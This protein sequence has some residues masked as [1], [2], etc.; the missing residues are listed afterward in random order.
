MSRVLL[1]SML[2]GITMCAQIRQA[3]ACGCLHPPEVPSGDFAVNQ[4]AE[5]IIFETEPGFVTAHILINYSGAPSSF[6]WIVPVPEAPEIG[7]SPVSAFAMIDQGTAPR[8]NVQTINECPQS[9]WSCRY[10]DQP[11]CGGFFGGGYDDGASPGGFADA[12]ASGDA[13]GNGGNPPVTVISTQRVGDY[14]TVTFRSDEAGAATQW[15][16]DNGFIVNSTMS[17][18]MEPYINAGMVFVAAKLA[19]GAGIDAIRPIKLRYHAT[20]PMVPLVLTAIATEP[21]LTVTSYIFSDNPYRPQGHPVATIDQT[22]I[23]QDA[24]G[25]TNYPMVVARSI[26]EAGGDAFVR[27][28][29]GTSFIPN[30]FQSG[31]CSSDYDVCSIGN[32]SKCQC[33]LSAF[34]MNDCVGLDDARDGVDFLN[35]M[36]QRHNWL[37]RL[38][39]RISAEE[40]TFD[41]QF[42]PDFTGTAINGQQTLNGQVHSLA[43]CTGDLVEL[44]KYNAIMAQQECASVYCGPG[45]R[46]VGTDQGPACACDG[47]HVAQQYTDLDNKP[48]IACVPTTPPVDLRAGGAQLP[49]ACAGVSC[50][51]GT[52]IDRNGVPVCEC[53]AGTAAAAGTGASPTC[54]NVTRGGTTPGAQDYS[55]GLH[56]VEVCAPAYPQCGDG[57]WL[58]KH[59][60]AKK[61]VACVNVNSE[62]PTALT[63]PGPAPTCDDGFLGCGGCSSNGNPV[64]ACGGAWLVGLLLL[65]RRRG[66][67]R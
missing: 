22:R 59:E 64:A 12:G 13:G 47:E 1:A 62:P 35:T 4:R 30:S 6:A 46:C 9:E 21:N 44:D 5:Q 45:G 2:A 60:V 31:C 18:Y 66:A 41:P 29:S 63:V 24:E 33:P 7:I 67:R 43:G 56:D 34:D 40:M 48:S 14:E 11:S 17:I 8:I 25:R 19:P 51:E 10:H 16:R 39:T 52:C 15:L 58:E 49:D 32:D 54:A 42:E 53:E 23:S 57:G 61:G 27:E 26:D 20:Y 38:T 50:G 28:Y 3:D 36:Q 65:R 55:T 37:T